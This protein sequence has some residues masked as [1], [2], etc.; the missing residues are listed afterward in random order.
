MN[1]AFEEFLTKLWGAIIV[2]KCPHC[3]KKIVNVKKEG[4]NKFF[5]L[6]KAKE[7]NLTSLVKSK[8]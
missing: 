1:S 7:E 8:K 6:K 5:I 4:S 2:G 3:S